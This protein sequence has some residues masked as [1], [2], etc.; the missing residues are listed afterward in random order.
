ML[1][2]PREMRVGASHLYAAGK[3]EPE[4]CPGLTS[5]EPPFARRPGFYL[6]Y[7]TQRTAG[8]RKRFHWI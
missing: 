6:Q 5:I 2:R 1:R 7:T 4:E 3:S 8:G